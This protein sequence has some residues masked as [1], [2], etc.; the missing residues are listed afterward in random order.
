MSS[1]HK[2]LIYKSSRKHEYT[3]EKWVKEQIPKD[4]I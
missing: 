3:T 2:E 1:F 4:E